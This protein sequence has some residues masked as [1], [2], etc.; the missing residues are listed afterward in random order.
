VK[1]IPE[2]LEDDICQACAHGS[3]QRKPSFTDG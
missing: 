2:W 1:A 3:D